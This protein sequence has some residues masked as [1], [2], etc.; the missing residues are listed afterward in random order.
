[1]PTQKSYTQSE[2][3]DHLKTEHKF[4]VF[5]SYLKEIVY[6]GND[7]IVTTFA[8][9]AGFSGA[10][11]TTEAS[12]QLSILTVLLF[13]IANLFADGTAM[14]LGSFLALRAEQQQ[15]QT[16]KQKELHEIRHNPKMERAETLF[17]LREKG[18]SDADAKTMTDLLQKNESY[19]LQFMMNDELELPN[20]ESENALL[21]GIATFLSFCLFGAIPILPY[22]MVS[23]PQT[24]FQI[25]CFTSFIA[26]VLLG[27]L[28]ATLS[29]RQWYKAVSET[30][31]VGTVSALIAFGV[32]F[33]FR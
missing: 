2:F 6:G 29:G 19:W 8:V 14:G 15:Y 24:A 25:S 28:S 32:G 22:L 7:G 3:E 10:Y 33:L 9:V 27:S 11:S 4:S 23:G 18:Y 13:S 26:L 21:T 1:M 16:A 20:P 5:S 12:L 30:V 17:I 31:I